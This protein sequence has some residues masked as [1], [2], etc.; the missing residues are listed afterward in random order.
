MPHQLIIG[1]DIGTTGCKAVATDPSGRVVASGGGGAAGGHYPLHTPRPGWVEQH[2]DEIWSAV[3]QSLR[4]VTGQLAAAD[5]AGLCLSGAM[6]SMMDV[7]HDGSPRSP[8]IIWADQR[9]QDTAALLRQRP[10][11]ADLY[12]RTGCP[13]QPTYHLPRLRRWMDTNATFASGD[14]LIVAVKDWVTHRLTGQWATDWSLASSTGLFNLASLTWDEQALAAAGITASRLPPL[15]DPRATV[16]TVTADAAV[17]TGLPHG[18]RVIAGAS[19]GGLAN[20]GSGAVLPGDTVVTAGTSG[21]IRVITDAPKLDDHQRTWCY[22]LTGARYFAGGA[23]NNAGLALRWVRDTFYSD[24]TDGDVFRGFDRLFADAAAIAPG[25]DGLLA[26]PYLTGDRS[27]HWISEPAAALHGLTLHHTRAHV[28]RAMIEGVAFCLADVWQALDECDAM[29]QRREPV[30]LTGGV[31]RA[32]L[33]RQI[34]IDVLGVPMAPS[35]AADASALGAAMLGH[36]A[37]G[38]VDSL[39]TIAG[40]VSDTTTVVQPDA[41]AHAIYRKLHERYVRAARR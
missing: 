39:E 26:L 30:R 20:L 12:R 32:P 23:I 25:A 17:Q 9:A 29:G 27:P 10:D 14:S 36:W 41:E 13:I 1:L 11:A 19:D 7:D 2:I 8:V 35:E 40:R 37:M 38:H 15:V 22:V 24:L 16:G 33:W 4:D 6:H 28:A 3:Q 34:I 18:L 31:A 5:I 21:A